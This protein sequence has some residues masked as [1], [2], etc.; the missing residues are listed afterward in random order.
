MIFI[1]EELKFILDILHDFS[2]FS[3]LPILSDKPKP[4]AFALCYIDINC[5]LFPVADN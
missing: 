2:F 4:L 5:E 3:F 1:C